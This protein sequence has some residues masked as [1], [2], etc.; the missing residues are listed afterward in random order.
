MRRFL[1]S[2]ALIAALALVG[3]PACTPAGG[4]T[5]SGQP[6]EDAAAEEAELARYMANLQRWTHKAALALEARNVELADFYLHEVEETVGT[7]QEEAPE[8]EGYPVGELTGELLVP[9]VDSLDTALDRGDWP[10]V[11]RRVEALQQ[12]CNDCHEATD[13]G[14]VRIDLRD[15]PNPYAQRFDTASTR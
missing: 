2:S 11:A 10:A 4:S 1:T 6:S 13:H 12:A 5:D 8:Y 14:F 7:V 9:A 15:L 3:A